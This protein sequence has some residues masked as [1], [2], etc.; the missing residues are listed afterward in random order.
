MA[1]A[2]YSS[3]LS[4]AMSKTGARTRADAVRIAQQNGWLLGGT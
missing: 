4:A 3:Y 1:V 2:S